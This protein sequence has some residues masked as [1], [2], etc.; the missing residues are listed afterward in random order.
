LG[1]RDS[2]VMDMMTDG[3]AGASGP[4]LLIRRLASP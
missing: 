1:N 3:I 4:P 2:D